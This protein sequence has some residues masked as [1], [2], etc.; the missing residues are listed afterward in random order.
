MLGGD[1]LVGAVKHT[2]DQVAG[3]SQIT[4]EPGLLRQRQRD[5]GDQ[6]QLLGAFR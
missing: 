2:S 3:T 1:R 6:R 5:G 4:A